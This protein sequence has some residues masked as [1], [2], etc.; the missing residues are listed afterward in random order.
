MKFGLNFFPVF[1][2]D[3][4]TG[5]QYF[6]EVL[7][8]SKSADAFGFEHV[9]TVEH[10]GTPYGGYSPDPVTL[11]AAI[12]AVTERIRITTG[13][14][15][16]AFTHPLKLAGKLAMLDNLSDGRLDVGFGRGFLPEEFEW[17]GIPMDESRRRFA[18]G[19]EACRRLWSET[20]VV[21]DGEFSSFGPVTLLPRPIQQPAPPIFLASAS[22]AESCAA[23]GAAG[24]HLQ[25]VP[26]IVSHDELLEML[27]AY[28]GARPENSS[29]RIQ[30]KYTCYL[31]EDRDEALL[32]GEE[33]E[34]NYVALMSQAV[35]SWAQTRSDQYAG[36]EKLIDKVRRYDFGKS[37]TDCKVLAG[38][39]GDVAQQLA[40]IRDWYGEDLSVSIQINPGYLDYE[41]SER[42]LRLF[43]DE[44]MPLFDSGNQA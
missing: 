44:V 27:A 11:L 4:K 6:R 23:A 25:V 35:A 24:Y 18:E 28:R 41:T 14:V 16:P 33:L 9:Q 34:N 31:S 10:Y 43:A 21:F 40:S 26:S 3:R 36:Y 13:A 17:F 7:E 1:A 37:L 5:A 30:I 22:S 15:I 2:P 12:A 19:V 8:L 38:T 29:G 39:P 32:R 20:D 42:T